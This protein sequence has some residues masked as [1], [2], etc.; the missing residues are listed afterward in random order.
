MSK[1]PVQMRAMN[2]FEEDSKHFNISSAKY[3]LLTKNAQML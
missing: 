2:S 1:Q 3:L